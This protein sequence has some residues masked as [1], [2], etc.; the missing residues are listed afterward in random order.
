MYTSAFT[1]AFPA[2]APVITAPPYEWPT[3]TTGPDCASITR[4]VVST[5]V[6]SDVSGFWTAIT[7][8]PWSWRRGMTSCQLEP[9]ANAPCTSTIV[10]LAAPRVVPTGWPCRVA[11]ASD[12]VDCWA[13]H[14]IVQAT[15]E[16][17]KRLI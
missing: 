10:G 8:Y 3:T 15:S 1:F 2:A 4:F 11:A 13:P 9:S 12:G 16:G 14:A 5:S 6:A 17:S 7:V